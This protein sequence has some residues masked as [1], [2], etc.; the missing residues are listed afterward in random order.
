MLLWSFD[1]GFRS[2]NS[3]FVV[4]GIV[5]VLSIVVTIIMLMKW[6]WKIKKGWEM[7]GDSHKMAGK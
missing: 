7:V 5:V 1:K 4:F 6:T 3:Y 2:L